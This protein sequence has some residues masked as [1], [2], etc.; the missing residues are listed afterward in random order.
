MLRTV[1]GT[2]QVFT[3]K[4]LLSEGVNKQICIKIWLTQSLE[5]EVGY[6]AYFSFIL[7]ILGSPKGSLGFFCKMAL[8]ALSCL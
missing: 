2:Q 5:G 6:K 3:N 1:P 4:C 7:E 8:V